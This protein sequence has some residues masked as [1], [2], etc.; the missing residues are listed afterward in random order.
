M[1]CVLYSALLHSYTVFHDDYVSTFFSRAR[2]QRLSAHLRTSAPAFL[3]STHNRLK[4]WR[5]GVRVL[6]CSKQFRIRKQHV[7]IF[8]R[9]WMW[10]YADIAV[11][12]SI[13]VKLVSELTCF[14]T[15]WC[16]VR[17]WPEIWGTRKLF[18]QMSLHIHY[19]NQHG[20]AWWWENKQW[21][22]IFYSILQ[23]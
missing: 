8:Y 1:S 2:S 19:L 17:S 12:S 7:K 10:W 4:T 13:Y 22:I 16:L 23:W 3:H 15:C 18:R 6:W 11:I 14:K 5:C 21:V 9:L 20:G